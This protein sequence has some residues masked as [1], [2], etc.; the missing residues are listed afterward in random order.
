MT[1]EEFLVYMNHF[2][3]KEYDELT[4]YFSDDIVVEY[5]DNFAVEKQNPKTLH[6]KDE[7]VANYMNLHRTVREFLDLGFCLFDG[8]HLIVELYTEFHALE[9]TAFSAG[10][11]KKGEA[12][13]VTN[14]VCYDFS[15]D[16]RFSHIRIAHF[17]VHDPESKRFDPELWP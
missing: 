2:N 14:W 17:R 10:K 7:F 6:G 9:D 3:N 16:G 5:F 1:R 8:E 15:P 12:L 11:L 4:K 13:C